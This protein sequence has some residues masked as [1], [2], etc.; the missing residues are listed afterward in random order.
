MNKPNLDSEQEVAAQ[1]ILLLGKIPYYPHYL[2]PDTWCGPGTNKEKEVSF[3]TVELLVRGAV[4]K[5]RFL[6]PRPWTA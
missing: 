4:F 3:T 1:K 2:K 6:W 5:K